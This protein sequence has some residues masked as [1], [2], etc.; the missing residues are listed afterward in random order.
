MNQYNVLILQFVKIIAIENHPIASEKSKMIHS[1]T[2]N[3]FIVYMKKITQALP[4]LILA[5]LL[6]SA[7]NEPSNIGEDLLPGEDFIDVLYT[8]SLL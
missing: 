8:D 5:I 6:G 3:S 1:F 7:C 4:V 2:Q